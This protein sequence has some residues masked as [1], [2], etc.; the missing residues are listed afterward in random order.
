MSSCVGK[1]ARHIET[2]AFVVIDR[3]RTS[4]QNDFGF[5]PNTPVVDFTTEMGAEMTWRVECFFAYYEVVERKSEVTLIFDPSDSEFWEACCALA[6]EFDVEMAFGGVPPDDMPEFEAEPGI[7]IEFTGTVDRE[8][9]KRMAQEA[10]DN[11][12]FDEPVH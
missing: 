2:E 8:T 4:N 1:Y 5:I 9:A 10:I 7:L 11:M 6:R 3:I 12:A